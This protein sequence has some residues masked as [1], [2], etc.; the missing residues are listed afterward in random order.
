[1]T[2]SSLI[3]ADLHLSPERP[4][5]TSCFCQFL[6]DSKN[7]HDSLYILGDL[8]EAWIGDDDIS[9]FTNTIANVIAEFAEST[10]VYF[11]HGNRD[12]L[13]GKRFAKKAKMTL[14]PQ[15]HRI[16]GYGYNILFM[17][18]D[19]LCT[20]DIPY[21]KFRR[22]SR[23]WWWKF[24]IQC[25]PLKQ[26]RLKA[27]N[28]RK[29]SV[30]QQKHKSSDIMDVNPTTVDAVMASENVDLLIHGHTHRPEIHS[31]P[32][33]KIRAVVGDWYTQGSVLTLSHQQLALSCISFNAK[34]GI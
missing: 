5:I 27:E 15:Q 13:L 24:L 17:H 26:R 11:I 7:K 33:N 20:D 9:P 14:L 2:N 19:Q 31:L 30:A 18:G 25:L 6:V 3:I 32:N 16:T 28:Y 34:N 1:M 10:P 8:F 21:Q 23:T 22:K 4:D 12:F 29:I